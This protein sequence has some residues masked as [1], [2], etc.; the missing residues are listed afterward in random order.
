MQVHSPCG[1]ELSSVQ[2]FSSGLWIWQWQRQWHSPCSCLCNWIH[3]C[4][5]ILSCSDWLSSSSNCIHCLLLVSYTWMCCWS[6]VLWWTHAHL[7]SVG[8][9]P[10][11]CMHSWQGLPKEVLVS[12]WMM[13][14]LWQGQTGSLWHT[15]CS[16]LPN[17]FMRV[18]DNLGIKPLFVWHWH[19]QWNKTK[20]WKIQI[21]KMPV[22]SKKNFTF[23]PC[24]SFSA[25]TQLLALPEM[26]LREKTFSSF[27][28]FSILFFFTRNLN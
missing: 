7:H 18:S 19:L 21:L 27:T 6:W 20:I 5:G 13:H 11:K 2:I 10:S 3:S 22:N 28:F 26:S 16:R 17:W 23:S 25:N 8:H 4:A 1:L 24:F 15:I 9:F 14:L 12:S